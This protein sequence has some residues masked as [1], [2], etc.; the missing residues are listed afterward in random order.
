MTLE[1][2]SH[3]TIEIAKEIEK[4]IDQH[5]SIAYDVGYDEGYDEGQKR[6]EIMYDERMNERYDQGW[7]DACQ[8]I[9]EHYLT[10]SNLVIT[11]TDAKAINDM[12][13][14]EYPTVLVVTAFQNYLCNKIE[15]MKDD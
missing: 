14:Q 5:S 10:P 8:Y 15:S 7:T 9:L 3:T 13:E 12:I 6:S 2:L 1:E 11:P 4:S